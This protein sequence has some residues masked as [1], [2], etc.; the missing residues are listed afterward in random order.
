MR[1]CARQSVLPFYRALPLWRMD[2]V[3]GLSAGRVGVLIVVHHVVADGLRG[4]E[5]IARL[6]DL[7][8]DDAVEPVK[9][10]RP[11]PTPTAGELVRDN[12]PSRTQAINIRRLSGLPQR[13]RTLRALAAEAREPRGRRCL[14][15]R[16]ALAAG[17]LRGQ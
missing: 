8:P 1:W 7:H 11:A 9:P 16:L 4:V 17:S 2:V 5:M 10:W 13:L 14:T 6:L 12:L 15:G 3:L